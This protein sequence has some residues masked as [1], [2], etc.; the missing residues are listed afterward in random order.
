MFVWR[1]SKGEKE[2]QEGEL[3]RKGS[4][5]EWQYDGMLCVNGR[6]VCACHRWIICECTLCVLGFQ[7]KAYQVCVKCSYICALHMI[8]QAIHHN[9]SFCKLNWEWIKNKLDQNII[10]FP[11]LCIFCCDHFWHE[12][13]F[14]KWFVAVGHPYT[15]LPQVSQLQL[16]I[17]LGEYLDLDND[18]VTIHNIPNNL[19]I[20]RN[21]IVS[22]SLFESVL[23]CTWYGIWG[24]CWNLTF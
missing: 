24:I 5:C 13:H 2:Y 12:F 1:G 3:M 16:N 10:F 14:D 4:R 15:A 19:S 20:A 17:E 8:F 18:N 21:F 11:F 22:R 9:P 6:F 7:T 23:T